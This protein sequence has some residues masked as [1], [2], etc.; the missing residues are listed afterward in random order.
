MHPYSDEQRRQEDNS[1]AA[2]V[3]H[4][5]Y[6]NIAHLAATVT[7]LL[8]VL[9]FGARFYAEVQ[10]TAKSAEKQGQAITRL[11]SETT[12]INVEMSALSSR[13]ETNRKDIERVEEQAA[14]D[15]GE[16]IRRLD[17]LNQNVNELNRYLRNKANNT[18]SSSFM[19]GAKNEH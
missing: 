17:L 10:S 15:R 11:R 5:P 13:V 7:L 8:T 2:K 19:Q 9:G 18:K 4:S 3:A 16:I 6:A 1:F 14:Q 12:D